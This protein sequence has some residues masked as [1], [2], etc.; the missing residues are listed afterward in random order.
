MDEIRANP[1]A[2]L[3]D[4]IAAVPELGGNRDLQ[5]AVL[6][7]TV[8]MWTS[9]YT[10]A[11]GTGAIDSGAWSKSVDFMRTLPESNIPTNLTVE[12]LVTEDLLP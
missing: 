8:E 12:Q 9:S 3:D 2:G 6:K 11:N 1:Q 10:Q 7:S 4:S 5:L